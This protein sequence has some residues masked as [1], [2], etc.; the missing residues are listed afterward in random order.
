MRLLGNKKKKKKYLC[1]TTRLAFFL[2][3]SLFS[4]K[5][6]RL[7]GSQRKTRDQ[8]ELNNFPASL[9]SLLTDFHPEGSSRFSR[10]VKVVNHIE[11]TGQ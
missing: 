2:F 3:L 7:F 1:N 9:M 11:V 4:I 8:S 6:K 10:T 5:E